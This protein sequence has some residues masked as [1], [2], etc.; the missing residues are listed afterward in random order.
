[1]YPMLEMS[2]QLNSVLYGLDA[3]LV[4]SGAAVF[5]SVLLPRLRSRFSRRERLRLVPP[6]PA[7]AGHAR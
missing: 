5:A 6:R 4:L 2:A 7:L 1:M 3:L